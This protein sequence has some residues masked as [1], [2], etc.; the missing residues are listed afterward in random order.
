MTIEH[1]ARERIVQS[2]ARALFV[3]HRNRR[4]SV[5]FDIFLA[6]SEAEMF[7]AHCELRERRARRKKKGNK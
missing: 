7:I 4:N 2:L 3:Q 1:V 5:D 6:F